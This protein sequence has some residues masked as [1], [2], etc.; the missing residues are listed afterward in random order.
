METNTKISPEVS[1][2]QTAEWESAQGNA[3]S[4][5]ALLQMRESKT[6]NSSEG[7]NV[8][9]DKV[10]FKWRSSLSQFSCNYEM[11]TWG[12]KEKK[13]NKPDGMKLLSSK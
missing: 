1:N 10:S 13:K 2:P 11:A 8:K 4:S 12:K 9:A 6:R 7:G 5:S 3:Y